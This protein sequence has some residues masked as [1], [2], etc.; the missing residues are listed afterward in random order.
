M[1]IL[2]LEDD[3][4]LSEII[5]A[6]L[7]ERGFKVNLCKDG[8]EALDKAYE[9]RYDMMILD[10]NV[11]KKSGLDVVKSLRG[12]NDKTP[13]IIIT[14]YQDTTHLKDGFESGCDDYIKKP[15]D[16]KELDMR[17]ENIKKRFSIE[18]EE[19]IVI[20]RD[21]KLTPSKNRLIV[22]DKKYK[23][24][25]KECEILIYMVSHK[26]QVIS[27]EELMRNLWEYEYMPSDATIRVYIKNLRNLIG[28]D[29]IK[30]IR[31]SG[32]YFE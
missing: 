7:K 16:L 2:L 10:I 3:L 6:R 31:G 4:V 17:I 29:K 24:A 8:E 14:A 22:G 9:E 1:K 32:Y 13:I 28:K 27:S 12:Y 11:P 30:T 18:S 25:R 5:E 26:K 21:I 20:D 15:F 19:E 23:L